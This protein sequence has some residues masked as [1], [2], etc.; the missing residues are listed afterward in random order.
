MSRW[1]LQTQR[2]GEGEA[3]AAATV[4]GGDGSARPFARESE[5][6]EGRP[7]E[8]EREVRGG[9]WRRAGDPGDEREKQDAAEDV[10]AAGC[11][12]AT[13]LLLLAGA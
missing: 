6:E 5:G 13:Q 9:A 4:N 10:A 8:R 2:E 11:G 3:V 12:A 1:S 7:R